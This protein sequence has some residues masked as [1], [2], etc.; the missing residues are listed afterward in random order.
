MAEKKFSELTALT[1]PASDDILAVTDTS[2]S[3]SK[4]ITLENVLKFTYLDALTTPAGADI[5]PIVDDVAGTPVAKKVTVD[6]LTEYALSYDAGT[7][8]SDSPVISL[9]Q[10]WNEGATTFTAAKLNVTDTASAAGSKL[11]DLQVG[12]ATKFQ[13]N[14]DGDIVLG[15]TTGLRKILHGAD[16]DTGLNLWSN[17]STT[18]YLAWTDHSGTQKFKLTG[19][20]GDLAVASL[21]S[22]GFSSTTSM[23]TTDV[24]LRRDA[25]NTLAQRNSTNAQSFN[26][27]NTYT[28]ASNYERLAIKFDTNVAT[29]ATEAAGTGTGRDIWLTTDSG[30]Y[31][32]LANGTT[33]DTNAIYTRFYS[34]TTVKAKVDVN[35]S[36]L[37]VASDWS[38]AFTSGTDAHGT[39]AD[40]GFV[41]ASAGVAKVTDG[42]T[43]NGAITFSYGQAAEAYTVATLPGTPTVGMMARVTDANSPSIGSTV[44]GSGAAAA[45]V[46]FNGSNWTVIGV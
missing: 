31:I 17:A 12:G 13:V 26:L 10:T 30:R 34:S 28:D 18:T 38:F 39:A 44:A 29:I 43:G 8:T 22:I 19:L 9:A 5:L 21:G 6:D 32:K 24:Y 20:Y 40:T 27:Y 3:E 2:A 7:I 37:Q 23:G 35:V 33:L 16:T 1:E 25:A 41:R 45:L 46:W 11:M 14:K 4:K 42:S 36:K 15:S